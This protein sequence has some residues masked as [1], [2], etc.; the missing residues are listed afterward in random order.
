MQNAANSSLLFSLSWG[1]YIKMHQIAEFN[2]LYITIYQITVAQIPDTTGILGKKC[3]SET[4]RW[5]WLRDFRSHRGRDEKNLAWQD[6]T[7]EEQDPTR[8]GG[9]E[10]PSAAL[11]DW[12]TIA[13]LL[14]GALPE[15]GR[16]TEHNVHPLWADK[17][18]CSGAQ[19]D[20]QIYT[21]ADILLLSCK[22]YF[23]IKD[24]WGF[25]LY[26]CSRR[27]ELKLTDSLDA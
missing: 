26:I 20:R 9:L 4:E 7:G 25:H 24:R 8:R 23:W 18:T 10:R 14:L 16:K 13:A 19:N 3:F 1:L 12:H 17:Y 21:W 11:P 5:W 6:E 22:S 27:E 15:F 2:S